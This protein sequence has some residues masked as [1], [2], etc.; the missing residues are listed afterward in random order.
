M[1][2]KNSNY[3]I[4]YIHPIEEEF[5]DF[6]L[7]ILQ[8]NGIYI[9]R[10]QV[11]INDRSVFEIWPEDTENLSPSAR[12]FLRILAANTGKIYN[13]PAY[14]EFEKYMH[15]LKEELKKQTNLAKAKGF[16]LLRTRNVR[17]PFV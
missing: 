2:C 6:I 1:E 3:G 4:I 12:E 15:E 9:T 13:H 16:S 10:S 17:K 11:T 5:A 7:F 14:L 8:R